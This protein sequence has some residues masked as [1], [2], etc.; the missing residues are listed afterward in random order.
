MQKKLPENNMKLI[1]TIDYIKILLSKKMENKIEGIDLLL[2]LLL[3]VIVFETKKNGVMSNKTGEALIQITSFQSI[4][5]YYHGGYLELDSE[6]KKLAYILSDY[7][8]KLRKN[9]LDVVGSK[10]E[11]WANYFE[12]RIRVL[13]NNWE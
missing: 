12:E 3:N 7:N 11:N 4:E 6:L 10:P 2:S 1:K 13:L 5:Y 9:E 8:E